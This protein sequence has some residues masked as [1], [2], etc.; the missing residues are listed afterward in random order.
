MSKKQPTSATRKDILD[1]I[2]IVKPLKP[3]QKQ[4][5]LAAIDRIKDKSSTNQDSNV[6]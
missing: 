2:K 5:I 4:D 1:I 6:Q 3:S